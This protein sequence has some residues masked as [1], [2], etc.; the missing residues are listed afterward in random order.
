[1][2]RCGLC[3]RVS[4][5]YPGPDKIVLIWKLACRY[6]GCSIV[7]FGSTLLQEVNILQLVV[8]IG[9]NYVAFL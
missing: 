3:R 2:L 9:L 7:L 6:V 5:Q 8:S 1:M 4:Q